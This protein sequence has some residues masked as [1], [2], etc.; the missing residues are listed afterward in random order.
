[1]FQF[2]IPAEVQFGFVGSSVREDAISSPLSLTQKQALPWHWMFSYSPFGVQSGLNRPSMNSCWHGVRTVP[3]DYKLAWLN[4]RKVSIQIRKRWHSRERWSNQP[5]VLFMGI[6]YIFPILNSWFQISCRNYVL[7]RKYIIIVI[8][9]QVHL[10]THSRAANKIF[11]P[12]STLL[13]TKIINTPALSS[14]LWTLYF[15][16]LAILFT[17]WDERIATSWGLKSLFNCKLA[18]CWFYF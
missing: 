4:A 6:K 8:I 15:F 16:K 3:I 12:S 2:Q 17:T 7:H 1:M 5:F 13:N 18:F 10:L 9:I 11:W 14:K